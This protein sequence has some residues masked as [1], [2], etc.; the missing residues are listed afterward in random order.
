MVFANREA[1]MIGVESMFKERFAQ[2]LAAMLALIGGLVFINLY[3]DWSSL[4]SG[5]ISTI[6]WLILI[7]GL[8]YA[9]VPEIRLARFTKLL[10]EHSW[11][12]MDGI[13]AFIVGL[14]LTGYGY[15]FW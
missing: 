14:Y 7:K 10:T 8:L 6:A 15:G 3:Q 9:F 4:P 12:T 13:L 11:Y 5:I 1:L 2:M